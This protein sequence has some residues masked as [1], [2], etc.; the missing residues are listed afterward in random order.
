MQQRHSVVAKYKS[1]KEGGLSSK[2]NKLAAKAL[3]SKL[4]K[5]YVDDSQKL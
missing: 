5:L 1:E 2:S 4:I 3:Y